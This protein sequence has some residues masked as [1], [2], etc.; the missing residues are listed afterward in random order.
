MSSIVKTE[1]GARKYKLFP[2]K[3]KAIDEGTPATSTGKT[4]P[5]YNELLTRLN[6][7]AKTRPFNILF[8]VKKHE[9]L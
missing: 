9:T 2:G 6:E 3:D 8:R 5:E 1:A 7:L 4:I